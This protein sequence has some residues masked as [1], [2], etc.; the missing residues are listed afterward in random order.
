[1]K[2]MMMCVVLLGATAVRGEPASPYAG[3]EVRAIK[4][5]SAAEID[6]YLDG[7]GMGF[8]KAAEL[9]HYP[10]PKHVLEMGDELELSEAQGS[11]TIA[12]MEAMKAEAVKLGA[13]VVAKERELDSGFAERT[14]TGGGLERLVREIASIQGKLRAAHL[15]AHIEQRAILSDEQVARYDRLRGYGGPGAH[16]GHPQH[17]HDHH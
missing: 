3:E 12:I 4:T 13:Q 16:D 9:N 1:M 5:L 11:R 15:R 8:A 10:G 17:G 14:I 2:T 7:A 6:G